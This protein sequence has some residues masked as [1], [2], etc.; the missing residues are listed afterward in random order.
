MERN[1]KLGLFSQ[2]FNK[3]ERGTERVCMERLPAELC[4]M[5]CDYGDS[6][7]TLVLEP[8]QQRRSHAL[9][10]YAIKRE[11]N[12]MFGFS[13]TTLKLSPRVEEANSSRALLSEKSHSCAGPT[14]V[15][16]QFL[17]AS[18]SKISWFPC[19]EVHLFIMIVL[20]ELAL[21]S[22]TNIIVADPESNIDNKACSRASESVCVSLF[23]NATNAAHRY[24]SGMSCAIKLLTMEHA[25]GAV[26]WTLILANSYD[27]S[28]SKELRVQT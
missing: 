3:K 1:L 27:C 5:I 16:A 15:K 28:R 10:E 4:R 17:S 23:L 26:S 25:S 7:D 18:V 13:L 21:S 9:A 24:R 8:H 6:L 11:K 22:T 12:A 19:R 2:T 20:G 14:T